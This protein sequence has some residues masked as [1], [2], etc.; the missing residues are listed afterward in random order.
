MVDEDNAAGSLCPPFDMLLPF[1][2]PVK[3]SLEV[4]EI[5]HGS[6]T[7]L[8]RCLKED[9]EHAAPMAHQQN[10]NKRRNTDQKTNQVQRA[11][12]FVMNEESRILFFL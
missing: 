1:N 5:M 11:G 9:A 3:H 2:E 4:F 7:N 12:L 10:K 6:C 8:W